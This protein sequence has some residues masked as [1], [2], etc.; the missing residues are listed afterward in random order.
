MRSMARSRHE[1]PRRS[2]GED[3]VQP[4]A[5]E[6]PDSAIR[7]R[8]D[9][10]RKSSAARRRQSPETLPNAVDPRPSKL[11]DE[12]REELLRIRHE[13]VEELKQYESDFQAD[14]G[15]V[16]EGDDPTERMLQQVRWGTMK[17]LH[18]RVK[19]VN[20]ALERLSEGEFGVCKDCGKRIGRPRLLA[21]PTA[22]RCLVCQS[23]FERCRR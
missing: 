13:L 7:V 15:V 23:R 21:N 16:A 6:S 14:V 22:T 2:H 5:A 4:P 12:T 8:R 11:Q 10:K 20:A 17:H 3:G 9:G 1:Q 18:G 19:E